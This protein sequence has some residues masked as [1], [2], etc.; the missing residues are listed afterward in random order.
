[1]ADLEKLFPPLDRDTLLRLLNRREDN[2]QQ[3][4]EMLKQ[5]MVPAL[6]GHDYVP[7]YAKFDDTQTV[8]QYNR[9]WGNAHPSYDYLKLL[10]MQMQNELPKAGAD[11][12]AGWPTGY[13]SNNQT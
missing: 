9:N 13:N 1:M 8:D 4:V 7:P 12:P 10:E 11:I 2:Y 6:Q 3:G 5:Q